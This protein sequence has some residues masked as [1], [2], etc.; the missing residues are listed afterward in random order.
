MELLTLCFVLAWTMRHWWDGRKNDYRSPD[1]DYRQRVRG[2]SQRHAGQRFA[3][4]WGLYQLRHGW[5]PMAAD[6]RDGWDGA[7]AAADRWRGGEADRPTIRDAWRGGWGGAAR[8]EPAIPQRP[9]SP[10][11]APAPAPIPVPTA[12]NVPVN[13]TRTTPDTTTGGT[14]AETATGEVNIGVYRLHLRVVIRDAT[15]RMEDAA[16]R[17][18]DADAAITARGATHD[19]LSGAGLGPQTTGGMA[20]LMEYALEERRE[21]GQAQARAEAERATA[22]AEL[23]N[24]DAQGHTTIEEA[25]GAASA[26]V[27]TD[28]TFYQRV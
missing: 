24:L 27:A 4:G 16:R 1:G 10:G 20:A 15:Q 6:V 21:A 8:P 13:P 14:M 11:P 12:P 3:A 26:P 19:S 17:I 22:E 28:T 25:V 18:A 23:A 7:H 9:G 5:G 2:A